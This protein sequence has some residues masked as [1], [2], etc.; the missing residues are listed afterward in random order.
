MEKNKEIFYRGAL[1]EYEVLD[2]ASPSYGN[3]QKALQKSVAEYVNK[4]PGQEVFNIL[5]AGYGTLITTEHILAASPKISVNSLE[6]Q[7]K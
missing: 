5:E 7:K 3:M 2:K 6:R 1:E 4:K